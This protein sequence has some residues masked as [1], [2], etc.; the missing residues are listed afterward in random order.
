MHTGIGCGKFLVLMCFLVL[1]IIRAA[2]VVFG[3]GAANGWELLVAV[4]I[5]FN[6]AFAPPAVIGYAF[7]PCMCP[8]IVLYL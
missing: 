4:E 1:E 6:F 2:E 8:R 3:T 7:R 5:E